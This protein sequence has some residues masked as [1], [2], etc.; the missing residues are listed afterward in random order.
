VAKDVYI[1]ASEIGEYVYC[2]RAWWLKTQSLREENTLMSEGIMKHQ[3]LADFLENFSLAKKL[4]YIL[5]L[6]LIVLITLIFLFN[7]LI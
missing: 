7:N 6:V 4:F 3:A 5:L 1:T 2:Q